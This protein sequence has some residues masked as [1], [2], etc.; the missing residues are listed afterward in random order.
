MKR[1]P[2]LAVLVVVL[3]VIPGEI[4]T[5][6]AVTLPPA[7]ALFDYQISGGYPPPDGVT[8]VSRDHED[9][10]APGLY[11]ICYVN[12][13]QAQS[14]TEAEWG[15]LLLRDENGDIV[16]D[17]DWDEALL[18]IRTEDKRER[19]ADRVDAWTDECADKGF[20][21]VEPD[22]YDSYTRSEN[23]LTE[24]HAQAHIR[25]LSAHAHQAGLAIGQKNTVELAGNRVANGLDF[26]VAEECGYHEECGGYVDAFGDNVIVIEY[27][28]DGL[29][30]ACAD[31]AD[32]LSIVLRDVEVSTPDS[33]DY[34]YATC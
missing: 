12:A 34:V 8:V 32:Q 3:L 24:D 27:T 21:A 20:Q 26:A 14:G 29:A 5:A 6:A 17:E 4:A 18:D 28:E 16:Y 19:I 15:D 23:L 22:N 30:T 1:A 31:W 13:F 11:N 9:D 7:H 25:L 33:A 2:V 10:P